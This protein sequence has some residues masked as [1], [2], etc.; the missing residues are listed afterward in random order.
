LPGDR[1]AIA[2]GMVSVNGSRLAE[3]YVQF[4]STQTIAPVTVP[5]G[6]VYV[7]G[8]NRAASDDSRDF[9]PLP[10]RDVIGQALVTLWPPRPLTAP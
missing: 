1:I 3:P 9:G 10:L 7:L 2:A 6:S 8:D 4:R 5:G